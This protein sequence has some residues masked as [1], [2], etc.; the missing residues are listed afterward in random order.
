MYTLEMPVKALIL[1]SHAS[2]NTAQWSLPKTCQLIYN[3]RTIRKII[4]IDLLSAAT[5]LAK[6]CGRGKK[7]S[8][9]VLNIMLKVTLVIIPLCSHERIWDPCQNRLPIISSR[10]C[11]MLIGGQTCS[12]GYVVGLFSGKAQKL[13]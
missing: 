8:Q 2:Q 1:L 3:A 13:E 10:R 5:R 9:T 4:E 7:K 6:K 12:R 11:N